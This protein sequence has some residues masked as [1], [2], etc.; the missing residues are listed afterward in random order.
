MDFTRLT[1][2]LDGVPNIGAPGVDCIVK[3][4][5]ETLYRH[6]AGYAD[7]EAKIEMTGSE[8]FFLYSTSKPITCTAVMQLYEQGKFLLTDPVYEYI[9]EFRDML[10]MHTGENG[11][12]TTAPARNPI[13]IADLLSMSSG[14]DYDLNAPEIRSVQQK[15]QGKAPT[16]EV[17]RALAARP[18][19]FEPG[20]HWQYSLSHDVLGALVEVVSGQRFGSYLHEHIFEP[21]GMVSTGFARTPEIEK[22]MM[23]QYRRDPETGVISRI[24]LENEFVLGSEYESG[25]AG[26]ISTVDDYSKFAAAMANGGYTPE[27]TRILSQATIDLM[28][29][30]RLDETKMRDYNW[31]FLGGY[32]YGLGVR[33]MIAPVLCGAN[34]PVGEFGWDGAAG[35][36][37]LIDPQ[38]GVS[39][40]YAQQM[41]E[42]LGYYVHPRLRNIIYSCL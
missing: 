12:T 18:L 39:V 41:R 20:T 16:L 32:G 30:N 10:V 29:T 25:G 36:Y 27:G 15:T 13:T 22:N 17:V 8:A 3:K 4:G 23:A 42:G 14:L 31:S 33:T 38:N 28:R 5:Y 35:S 19:G 40:F 24:P 11:E 37:V 26:L 2:F 7:R 9:P 34:S 6:H 1:S 21:L